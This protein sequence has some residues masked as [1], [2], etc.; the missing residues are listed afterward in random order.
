MMIRV[1]AC[2]D[3]SHAG[4]LFEMKNDDDPAVREASP[5]GRNSVMPAFSYKSLL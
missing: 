2:C 3:D 1:S 5:V 4:I